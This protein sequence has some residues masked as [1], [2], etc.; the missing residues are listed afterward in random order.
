MIEFCKL[1]IGC[2]VIVLYIA[3]CY[4]RERKSLPIKYRSSTFDGLLV[5]GIVSIFFDMLTAYFV[6][7]QDEIS[8]AAN[9]LLHMCFLIGLDAVAFFLFWYTLSITDGIP[10][11]KSRQALFWFPFLV[12]ILV[13]VFNIGTLEF[14]RGSI[15]NYSMGIS[16]YTC[17][18]MAAVYILLSI[19]IFYWRWSYIESHKRVI[20]FT[21]L[22]VIGGIAAFQM[23]YP[24]SLISCMAPTIVILGV[25][26]NQENPA[27]KKLSYYHSEMVMG[28]AT[29]V[30][31]KDDST[32]GHI[33]RTTMY[34]KLLAEELRRRGI[35]RNIL[36][37][38]YMND[39]LLAAPMHDIGKIAIPD[40][41]LQKPG[42]LTAEEYE[43][44]K[45]HTVSGGKI[46]QDTFG[47]LGRAQYG[48]IVYQVARYHHE[49][50]NGAGYPEG[51]KEKEIPLC[52]RIMAIADVF[53]AVSEKRCYR[54]AMPLDKCFAIIAEGSGTDFEPILVE[55]FLDMREK[56]EEIH[57]Q[58]NDL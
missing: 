46:V 16:V 58:I 52:A 3:F 39:L 48:E 35:Y 33:K 23:K 22:L 41:I 21:Y 49:K 1:Q 9:R 20:I 15:T 28:F 38:D 30:E 13:V 32:G 12:N 27:M 17:F 11:K 8:L 53:D 19:G 24:E 55:V 54:D 47:H 40:A 5:L 45:Q 37:K 10:K 2:L 7:H 4:Y 29:L 6:N 36:T 31:N 57:S 43:K 50:W 25:Y 14:R 44:M 26:L 34:V 18:I 42:K 56:V 51:R